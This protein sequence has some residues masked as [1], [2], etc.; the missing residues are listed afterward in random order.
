MII[1][2]NV[3]RFSDS[4]DLK[5]NLCRGLRCHRYRRTQNIEL[6]IR[7][8]HIIKGGRSKV[9]SSKIIRPCT[10]TL[11]TS[12]GLYRMYHQEEWQKRGTTLKGQ[13]QVA[14]R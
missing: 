12:R 7:R 14:R 11:T 6:S 8:F 5:F 2:D 10:V 13:D 9:T 4:N 1:S 3:N